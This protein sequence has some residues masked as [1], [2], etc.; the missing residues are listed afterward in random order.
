MEVYVV[1]WLMKYVENKQD[2]GQYG[3]EKGSSISHYLVEFVNF[4]LYNQDMNIPQ[5]VLAVLLDYSKAL[6]QNLP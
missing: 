2:W 3:G 5:A 1:Q 6:K 4:I